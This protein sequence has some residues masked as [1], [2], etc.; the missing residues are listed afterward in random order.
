LIAELRHFYQILFWRF[1]QILN[2]L[3]SSFYITH[4]GNIDEAQQC[5]TRHQ[6][7][8]M[9]KIENASIVV[10]HFRENGPSLTDCSN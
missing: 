7:A 1:A 10:P 3:F 9:K 2:L 5:S 6:M 8:L 4:S